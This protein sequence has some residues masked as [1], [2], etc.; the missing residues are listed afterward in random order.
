MTEVQNVSLWRTDAGDHWKVKMIVDSGATTS[1]VPPH[2]IPGAS[3]EET[4]K[5]RRGR[6]IT[7]KG[8]VTDVEKPLI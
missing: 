2:L 8:Q 4:D 3:Y 1:V 5:T 7:L 6:G